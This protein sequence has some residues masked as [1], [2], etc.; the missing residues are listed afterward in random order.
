MVLFKNF[1]NFIEFRADTKSFA[2]NQ[3]V[4]K[5]KELYVFTRCSTAKIR[6]LEVL[7]AGITV[8]TKEGWGLL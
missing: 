4:L 1:W 8:H 3:Q 5:R 6:Q 7:V 2:Q